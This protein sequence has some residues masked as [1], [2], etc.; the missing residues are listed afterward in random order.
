MLKRILITTVGTLMLLGILGLGF[1]VAAP[2]PQAP[3]QDPLALNEI[4]EADYD[5]ALGVDW[6][7]I[8]AEALE[9]DEDAFWTA[10]EADQSIAQLAETQDIAPQTLIDAIVTAETAFIDQLIA[11][12]DL[13]TEEAAEWKTDITQEAV[14]FINEN[15]WLDVMEG[16]DWFAI[17]AEELGLDEEAFWSA[18]EDEQSIAQLAEAQ[19]IAPQTLIDAI[20][21]AEIDFIDQFIVDG[22]TTEEEAIEWKA[23]IAEEA[24]AFINN[25]WTFDWDDVDV[26][27][28]E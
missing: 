15:L 27:I 19:G 11:D 10:L 22:E 5:L 16:I 17:V 25:E 9:L 1:V 20:V 13:T 6:F 2:N 8:V 23:D 18:F 12:E 28:G 4:A 14:E 26:G 3:I 7:A 24:T 21:A